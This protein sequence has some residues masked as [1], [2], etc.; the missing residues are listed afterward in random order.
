M[1]EQCVE[2]AGRLVGLRQGIA[3]VCRGV[4]DDACGA[5]YQQSG[6]A[7]LQVDAG[8]AGE[9][10]LPWAVAARIVQ[11]LTWRGFSIEMPG[12]T[13][14]RAT[15]CMNGCS[16]PMAV[17]AHIRASLRPAASSARPRPTQKRR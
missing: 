2:V 17:A 10:R 12:D 11:A 1:A 14:T 16:L 15:S 9:R 3:G 4:P 7:V 6:P 13:P 8:G 5:G